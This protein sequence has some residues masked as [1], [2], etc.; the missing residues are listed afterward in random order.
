MDDWGSLFDSFD[1]II[2]IDLTERIFILK[3]EVFEIWSC[4]DEDEW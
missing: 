3:I 2:I 4:D 1:L